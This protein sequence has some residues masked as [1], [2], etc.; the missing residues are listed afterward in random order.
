[1]HLRQ[2]RMSSEERMN[3]LFEYRK[4]DRIP[5]NPLVV[6]HGFNSRN[7]GYTIASAYDAPKETFF[8][9]LWTSEQYGWDQIHHFFHLNVSGAL[10]FGGEVK[11]PVGEFEDG[12]IVQS[13]PVKT[14]TDIEKLKMPD[15]K[16]AGRIPKAMEFSK[17]VEAHGRSIGFFSRAPFCMA[18][19][20][21]DLEQ[22]SRW[23]VRKPELCERL[24]GM[25]MDHIFNVLSYWVDVFGA[26]KIQVF[27]ASANESNQLISPKHFKKYALPAHMEFHRRL[28]LLGIKRFAFHLC[29]D[30]NLNLPLLASATPWMH[31]SILSFGH[32]VDLESAG[33]CF[34]Q[35]I[36]YGNV[37]PAVIQTGTPQQVYELSKVT[38]E[39]GKRA[40]GGF[41][42]G[43]GCAIPPGSPPVNVFSMTKAVNDFGWYD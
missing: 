43:P 18:A 37:E 28:K 35:D 17:L 42:L 10:D 29:G 15:P 8:A 39:K 9:G 4:P 24:T 2:D 12:M 36:I 13:P 31:P 25:A 16:K 26:E 20:I 5:I 34:P 27:I 23:M 38:I 41:I 7:A 32:E 6:T 40:P 22:F 3:A 1:M 30:Q 11:L 33:A 14:E 21:C 19:N